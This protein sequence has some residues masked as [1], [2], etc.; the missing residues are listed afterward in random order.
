[1]ACVNQ[2]AVNVI[3]EPLDSF[4]GKQHMGCFTVN[5]TTDL[6]GFYFSI[7][8]LDTEFYVWMDDGVASD[9]AVVGKTGIAVTYTDALSAS[10]LADAIVT[11][12]NATTGTSDLLAKKYINEGVVSVLILSLEVG[13]VASA[14]AV[15]TS[16]FTLT[17][18]AVGSKLDLGLIEGDI[19]IG[20]EETFV[21]VTAHQFGPELLAQLRTANNFT[22]S[23]TLKEA[24]QEK[25]AQLM[26]FSAVAYTPS[27]GTEV[28]AYGAL[29]GSKQF[30]STLNDAATLVLHPTRLAVS[31]RTADY[32]FWKAYPVISEI[33]HSGEN[34]KSVTIDFSF[35]IDEYKVNEAKKMV[36]GDWQQNFL[37]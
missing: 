12:V 36:Y 34:T 3:V 10:A 28:I 30:Q 35:F 5:N 37:V 9:P 16:T 4:L 14:W 13:V 1:M 11:A 33:L 18:D 23:L 17:L 21:D 2:R 27:G 6:A 8:N 26:S 25:I 19:T 29:A 7:S 22:L 15:N 24:T 32:C 20:I 31:D